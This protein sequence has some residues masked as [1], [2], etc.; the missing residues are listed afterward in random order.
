MTGSFA[1]VR[2]GLHGHSLKRWQH[3]QQYLAEAPGN[4]QQ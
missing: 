2:E 4:I 3:Y 1:Q